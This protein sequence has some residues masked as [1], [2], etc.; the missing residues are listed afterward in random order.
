M[1]MMN[2]HN[3]VHKNFNTNETEKIMSQQ[4][5]MGKV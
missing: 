2:F 1:I 4:A 5:F 3:V